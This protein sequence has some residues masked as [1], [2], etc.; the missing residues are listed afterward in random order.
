[1]TRVASAATLIGVFGA[2]VWLAPPQATTVL[3][4]VIAALAAHE[5]AG[6]SARGGLSTPGLWMAAAA[7]VTA[8]AVAAPGDRA[9]VLAG[10]LAASL[11]TSGLLALASGP[12]APSSIGAAGV[13]ALAPVYLGVPLGLAAW[14]R[15]EHGPAALSWLVGVIALSDTAQFY[16]GRAIGRRK[17]APAVSPAK[18]VEGAIGGL[19]VAAAFGGALAGWGLSGMGA[20][21]GALVAFAVAAFGIAGDLFESLIKRSAGVKDSSAL[22]PGH[23][24]VLDRIDA[25]LFA[26]PALY[27]FLQLR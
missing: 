11:V 7:G 19:V 12:P 25:Y 13:M 6:L 15:V 8:V 16:T 1:M 20:V 10:V 5:L 27:L 14:L 22:I 4:A 18:T 26:A 21:P 24:G 2:T 17:L 9:G 23:G 3:A